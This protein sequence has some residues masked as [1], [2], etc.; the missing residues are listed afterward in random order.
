[1]TLNQA[2]ETLTAQLNLIKVEF[3]EFC[4][5]NFVLRQIDDIFVNAGFTLPEENFLSDGT[6]RGLVEAYY[7]HANWEIQ[8]TVQNFLK[9]IEYTLQLFKLEEDSKNYL[10]NLCIKNGFKIK[11]GKIIREDLIVRENL[12]DEQFPA[13]LPFG[14]PK[15][16]FSITAKNGSQQLNFELQ[17]GLGLLKGEVY[18]N[19]SWNSLQSLYHLTNSTDETLRTSLVEMN[20]T[21]YEKQFF[22]Q[23]ANILNMKYNNI[24]VLIPQAWIQWHSKSRKNLRSI[25][26]SHSHD[27]YRVD[28]VAFWN[29]K[30]FVILVDDISHYAIK[31]HSNWYA[32]EESYAKRL[33]EDRKLRKE[34]W[35]VFR[36]SNWE[37]K[38]DEKIKNILKDLR[39]FVDF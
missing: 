13:G 3:R 20:Q 27:I 25:S 9:V 34:N 22:R 28:F 16:D 24:P 35:H 39:E 10:R 19:F 32:D 5:D 4:V 18:P 29:N 12:F 38:D 2:T 36:V 1:M 31:K 11:D 26:S 14:V 7:N 8:E 23:Y 6:R 17:S 21:K 30:R 15:P 37:L 33:K